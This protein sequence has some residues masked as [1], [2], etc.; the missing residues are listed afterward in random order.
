MRLRTFSRTSTQAQGT[1]HG[2]RRIIVSALAAVFPALL[3]ALFVAPGI[4][5]A[6]ATQATLTKSDPAPNAVLTKAPTHLTL[7]F[8]AELARAGSD[9][10][11]Y[12][13]KGQP[14]SQGPL[15]VDKQNMSVN[16]RAEGNG[17]YMVLWHA[18][19]AKD[20]QPTIGAYTYSV[21]SAGFTAGT[22]GSTAAQAQSST[23]G[24]PWWVTLV[25]GIVG[26]VVGIGVAMLLGGRAPRAPKAPKAPKVR[27]P[28]EE[29][30]TAKQPQTSIN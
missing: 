7:T 17:V 5:G 28:R 9:I 1:R 18:T 12:T 15:V 13:A 24:L 10:V 11:V 8:S 2:I 3:I 25:A 23:A 14:I 22:V 30:E 4:A 16:V 27:T 6:A 21:G 20:N 19:S 26:L 29:P